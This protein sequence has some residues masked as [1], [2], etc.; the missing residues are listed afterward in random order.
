MREYKEHVVKNDSIL[1]CP[2]CKKQDYAIV[3]DEN[4]KAECISRE[5]RRAYKSIIGVKKPK[6]ESKLNYKCP[7]CNRFVPAWK[8]KLTN[9]ENEISN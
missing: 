9:D 7:H 1:I 3:W 4:T 5:L 6:R 8:I 2:E